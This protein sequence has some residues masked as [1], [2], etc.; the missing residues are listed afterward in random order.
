MN[1]PHHVTIPTRRAMALA[2]CL[3]A[4][5]AGCSDDGEEKVVMDAAATPDTGPDPGWNSD[6]G[7]LDAGDDDAGDDASPA[8]PFWTIAIIPDTQYSFYQPQPFFDS[9]TRWIA[10]HHVAERIAFVLHEGDIV[11]SAWDP[12]QWASARASMGLLDGKVPY[13]LA[14]GNH[15]L[16]PE[17]TKP[18]ACLINDYFLDTEA[19]KPPILGGLYEPGHIE[20]GYYFLQGGGRTWLVLSLEWSPRPAVVAWANQVLSQQAHLPAILL[21]HAYLYSDNTRYD[22]VG[23]EC[24]FYDIDDSK[25]TDLEPPGT[26]TQ[27]WNPVCYDDYTDGADGQ[28]LWDSLVSLHSNLLFVFS[29][30]V[31]NPAPF[32]AGRLSSTRADGTVCHQIMADYQGTE[33]GGAGYFR[34]VRFWPDGT[35]RVRTFSAY[36]SPEKSLLTDD[37][38]QFT[39]HVELPPVMVP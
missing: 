27:C 15:D 8:E 11:D 13:V 24:R 2:G 20:N 3:L 23:R 39:L 16:R 14:V 21:T 4:A 36:A 29:G 7:S 25:C 19:V 35:V 34:L 17:L 31:A 5:W 1:L 12:G 9:E 37:R 26:N 38:N 18:R 6:T 10:D 28:M 22:H 33:Y 30:H 32:V